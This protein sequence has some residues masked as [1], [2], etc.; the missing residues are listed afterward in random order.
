M[1]IGELAR[2]TGVSIRSLRYYETK[3][4]LSPR[5]GENG[6]RS[7]KENAVE[8]VR[9]IQ[10]YLGLGLTTD[11]IFR[12]MDGCDPDGIFTQYD[13]EDLAAC[14]EEVSLYIEKLAEVEEQIT[15]LEQVR[16]YLKQRLASIQEPVI[17]R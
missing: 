17:S 12:V 7:Y 10:F 14:P 16:R 6:Y 11:E 15:S 8:Q 1:N 9:A 5:R 2:H 13:E 3:Q 4:L